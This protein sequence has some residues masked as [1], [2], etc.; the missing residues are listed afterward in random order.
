MAV[1]YYGGGTFHAFAEGILLKKCVRR[2]V[3]CKPAAFGVAAVNDQQVAWLGGSR[4][5]KP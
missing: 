3:C 2:D 1:P 5:F 4:R